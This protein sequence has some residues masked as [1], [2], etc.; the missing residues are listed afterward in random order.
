MEDLLNIDDLYDLIMASDTPDVVYEFEDLLSTDE[1]AEKFED[2]LDGVYSEEEEKKVL[3]E[4]CLDI[5]SRIEN[6]AALYGIGIGLYEPVLKEAFIQTIVRHGI[7]TLKDMNIGG[8]K[9]A[10]IAALSQDKDFLQD[11]LDNPEKYGIE[12]YLAPLKAGHKAL[13]GVELKE[14][15]NPK[16]DR[17]IWKHTPDTFPMIKSSKARFPEE[18]DKGPLDYTAAEKFAIKTYEGVSPGE[19]TISGN[20]KSYMTLN[21]MFFP[22]ID[23]E[24]ERIFDDGKTLFPQ[25]LYNPNEIMD[26][27]LSLYSAMY[28]YGQ[29]MQEDQKAFRVDR[30]SSAKRIYESG[31]TISNFST[32]TRKYLKFQK[33]D[34][35]LVE[36]VIR[37]G[38]PC[39]DF[40]EILGEDEYFLSAESEILVAPYCS[41]LSKPP[42]PPQTEEEL[43]QKN[44]DKGPASAVYEM[45][46]S[47][48]SEM[49]DLTEEEYVD[50]AEKS[51]IFL[52]GDRKLQ[53]ARFLA[54][55][56]SM[57]DSGISKERAYDIIDKDDLA[58]YLEWKEAFQG[59]YRY[60]I[61][62]LSLEIDRNVEEAK[63]AGIP[64][65]TP[66]PSRDE[67]PDIKGDLVE[68]EKEIS[69]SEID[70]LAKKRDFDKS[71]QNAQKVNKFVVEKT[72]EIMDFDPEKLDGNEQENEKNSQNGEGR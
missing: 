33:K 28:K 11:C 52:D 53:A 46:I 4:V 35:A 48:P 43:S 21:A 72:K 66:V 65:F 19:G 42:R 70:K 13:Y 18:P 27:S 12:D 24:M 67:M 54:K 39:A 15:P 69:V 71:K 30:A 32:S 58:Q 23:N 3:E 59:L 47:K 41:V 57:G 38:T 25:I 62:Q 16:T 14:T 61:R 50:Y 29:R 17:L 44:L 45:E 22:G 6:P 68:S 10:D 49:T 8:D 5:I 37:K 63:E 9:I 36:A 55:L 56:Q 20:G 1:L 60:N 2:A 31:K 26:I 7:T 34:I 51:S 64:L 40:K